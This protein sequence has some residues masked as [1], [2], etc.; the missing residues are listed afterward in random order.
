[1]RQAFLTLLVTTLASLTAGSALAAKSPVVV[2][3]FTAQGCSSCGKANQVVADLADDKGVL[4]LTYSV[5]YWD[6]LGWSDTFAKP[7][8][9]SRQ[10]AYAQKFSLR[11]VPTPQV[12]ISG[13]EQ[14]SGAKAEAVET[15]V[16]TAA[17]AP[18]N[19][20]DMEF[21]GD[22]RVAV[23]SGPAPRGGGEVW[24]V[25]YDPREQEIA[26][27]RGDNRGQTLVHRNVVRELTRL[28]PWAGRP[29][30][31]RLTASGDDA[32]KT[33][34]IVQ[35]AKGGRVIGVLQEETK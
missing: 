9:A 28:G 13:R 5:D 8:F 4:A 30:L 7:A 25:R 35:G 32:L 11:D 19:P 2:E 33:V 34:I 20:P 26:V 14:A 23:G 16:K 17:K 24:L 6:Y 18:A 27:K 3:L 10:R 12:V 31:Y 22:N 29:K 15:L 1:M 21:V